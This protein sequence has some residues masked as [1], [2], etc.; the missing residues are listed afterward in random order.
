MEGTIEKK[1]RMWISKKERKGG[2]RRKE[3]GENGAD[4]I[5]EYKNEK[6]ERK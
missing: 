4:L 2:V 1:Q 6:N 3:N 5:M